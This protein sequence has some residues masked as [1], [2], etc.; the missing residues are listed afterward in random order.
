MLASSQKLSVMDLQ[1]SLQLFSELRAPEVFKKKASFQQICH[2]SLN[3]DW[4]ALILC[5]LNSPCNSAGD[6]HFG[7]LKYVP[8]SFVSK[9][10]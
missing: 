2:N 3:S 4:I 7:F 10:T 9:T 5:S 1:R 6:H 8:Y